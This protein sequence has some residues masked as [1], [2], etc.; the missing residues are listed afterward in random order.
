M[1]EEKT[2]LVRE[3]AQSK[4][5]NAELH[6]KHLIP[7]VEKELAAARDGLDEYEAECKRRAEE[8]RRGFEETKQAW[9]EQMPKAYQVLISS[10]LNA[11]TIFRYLV[12]DGQINVLMTTFSFCKQQR[13]VLTK[14]YLFEFDCASMSAYCFKIQNSKSQIFLAL[15]RPLQMS[16][17]PMPTSRGGLPA[18]RNWRGWR[19]R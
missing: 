14:Q 8:Y 10:S 3:S 5:K 13:G 4:L 19:R 17:E 7:E 9:K 16:F 1:V 15:E 12:P 6:R 11:M 18:A 2:A